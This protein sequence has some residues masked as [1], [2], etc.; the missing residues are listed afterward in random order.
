[1]QTLTTTYYSTKTELD[2]LIVS[3]AG[4]PT[5]QESDKV[6]S[7]SQTLRKK[8]TLFLSLSSDEL[9]TPQLGA[10]RIKSFLAENSVSSVT[11]LISIN[12]ASLA[13]TL[14]SSLYEVGQLVLFNPIAS[15]QELEFIEDQKQII[16]AIDKGSSIVKRSLAATLDFDLPT[17]AALDTPAL[18]NLLD[19]LS[20][21]PCESSFEELNAKVYSPV[22]LIETGEQSTS[23]ALSQSY[24]DFNVERVDLD[25]WLSSD[26]DIWKIF[27]ATLGFEQSISKRNSLYKLLLSAWDE[28]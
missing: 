5:I 26:L 10:Q 7:L 1:M 21:L 12:G 20:D 9:E 2:Y 24:D 8:S 27:E 25:K 19:K 28:R 14:Y 23:L 18:I 17:I 16:A 13:A 22:L 11:T 4:L 15:D 3:Q 6:L